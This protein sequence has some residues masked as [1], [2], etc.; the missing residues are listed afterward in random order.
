V[1]EADVVAGYKL[2]S[3]ARQTAEVIRFYGLK[4][5]SNEFSLKYLLLFTYIYI[6]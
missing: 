5:D 3:W 6:D 2:K 4:C 1:G